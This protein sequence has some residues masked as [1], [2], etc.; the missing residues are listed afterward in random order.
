MGDL[1]ITILSDLLAMESMD[2]NGVNVLAEHIVEKYLNPVGVKY[3]RVMSGGRTNLVV[4]V[5]RDFSDDLS[6]GLV[7]SGH[8]DTVP[9]EIPVALRDG[10]LY[11][12]GAVDMKAFV[13]VILALIPYFQKLPYPVL[14]ALTADEETTV[15][16]IGAVLD[17][18]GKNSIRPKYCIVGE[19]CDSKIC[20]ASPGV[21]VYQTKF[22]GRPAHASMPHLGINTIVAASEFITDIQKNA[23]INGTMNN[24]ITCN[25][26]E[27]HGGIADNIVPDTCVLTYSF[28]FRTPDADATIN[29]V[30]QSML[31]RVHVTTDTTRPL[32]MPA[33]TNPDSEL[34]SRLDRVVPDVAH[35]VFFGATEA[36][37]WHASGVD[38]II[39]GPGDMSLAHAEK[40]R[41]SVDMLC[42]YADMLQKICL[43]I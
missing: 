29:H 25:I 40:E 20:L 11:G 1:Y 35:G 14:F 30:V 37:Y 19:P 43:G 15:N 13:A 38:T 3:R 17:F 34:A 22:M 10:C 12:R 31:G 5:N 28:R 23:T 39:L 8:M 2:D 32:Y 7:L 21:T 26:A 42:P 27:I 9:G 18:C 24:S 6:G 4:A 41:I 16:G 36:G 33:F